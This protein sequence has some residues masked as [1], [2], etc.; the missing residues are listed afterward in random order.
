MPITKGAIHLKLLLIERV[1]KALRTLEP[2]TIANSQNDWCIRPAVEKSLQVAIEAIIDVCQRLISIGGVKVPST[3]AEFIK[4]CVELV[5]LA[6]QEPYRLMVQCLSG[7]GP[8][9]VRG[10]APTYGRGTKKRCMSV[11]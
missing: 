9:D 4:M 1:V 2:L 5:A 11:R 7:T 3:G 10:I 6:S 8:A